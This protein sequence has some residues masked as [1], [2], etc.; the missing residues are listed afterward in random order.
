[1][2]NWKQLDS[3]AI[4]TYCK[5]YYARYSEYP[6]LRDIFYRFVGELWPNTK[7]AYKGLSKWLRDHRLTG[8]IDWQIIRDGAG[9]Q[10]DDNDWTYTTSRR[11]VEI[12][13]NIFTRAGSRYDLPMW[14]D[15]PKKVIVLT[16]KEA[17]YPII[18]SLVG[19][20]R[21][22]VDTAYARGYS[23]W[24]LLFEMAEKIKESGRQPVIIALADFDPSGGEAA[25][26]TG[27][28]LVSFI[29]KA[30]LKLG[31]ADVEVEKI[32]VTKDQVDEFKLPHRPEDAQ[33]IAKLQRDPR[34]K[35]WPWGLYR[36][37]TAAFR[38]KA[39]DAFDNCI[40]E[41]VMNHF[42]EEIWEKVKKRQEEL[43]GKIKEFFDDQDYLID[44]LRD[45]I[46]ES[47]ILDE[48]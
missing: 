10:F 29:L 28:D 8:K 23:G 2:V 16:E 9:R 13:L 48:E 40:K 37:E 3:G 26:E 19:L 21:M 14:L 39:P 6:S 20:G 5:E 35:T 4:A 47:E 1:M 24:R 12:W 27:K 45:N 33:E 11:Q 22:N 15:Q 44:D 36:V 34:F 17:D 31:I 30:M 18:E 7:S 42:D 41:A 43:R 32:L 38:A 25:K 46:K